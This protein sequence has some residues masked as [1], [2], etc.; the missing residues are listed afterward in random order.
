MSALATESLLDAV[1]VPEKTVRHVNFFNGRVLTA[2][3]LKAQQVADRLGRHQLGR[4]IGAGVATGF[5]TRL[6]SDGT[7]G[8]APIVEVTG[9]LAIT[10]GGQAIELAMDRVNVRLARRNPLL[11]ID[12]G[13]FEDCTQTS[14]GGDISGRGAYVLVVTAASVFREQAPK[15]EIGGK[16]VATG[17]GDRYAVEGVAFRLVEIPTSALAD[18]SQDTRDEI[19]TLGTEAEAQILTAAERRA[20]LSR[21]RNVLAHACLGSEAQARAL[22]DPWSL[23]TTNAPAYGVIDAMRSCDALGDWD[24]PLALVYWT[25]RGVRFLD[26]WSVR[27]RPTALAATA[28]WSITGLRRRIEA[29]ARFLQFEDHVDGLIHTPADIPF[30]G[31][32]T[33]RTYFHH[34]PPVGF[35]PLAGSGV[36]GGF[37]GSLIADGVPV[38][39]RVFM[40]GSR[41]VPLLEESFGHVPVDLGPTEPDGV[42]REFLWTYVIR[43]NQQ[44]IDNAALPR[45]RLTLVFTSGHLAFQADPHYD[46]ARYGYSN[47]GLGVEAAPIAGG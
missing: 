1:L 24:V 47:Y 40:D 16:G 25:S 27:R 36:A 7:D 18:V 20:R 3:D 44:A 10:P 21:L 37:D 43:Q 19:T 32:A 33:L 17:C 29:E 13:L 30:L 31:Q 8:R 46:L 41:L 12:I 34:V 2:S 35:I 45:P 9:G 22:S 26:M 38:R 14:P 23:V 39:D 6:V 5:E 28:A 42:D 11:P 15:V 4:V